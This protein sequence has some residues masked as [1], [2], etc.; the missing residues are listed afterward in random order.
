[1]LAA[2]GDVRVQ[3]H[4]RVVEV[5]V[6]RFAFFPSEIQLAAGEEVELVLESEDT[7]HGFHIAGTSTSVAIPKRGQGVRSVVVRFDEPGRYAFECSRMCG[8]GH[9]FMRGEIVVREVEAGG[10]Q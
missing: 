5:T 7:A 9:H 1:M 8:A 10:R 6:E 4:R 2:S 3:E